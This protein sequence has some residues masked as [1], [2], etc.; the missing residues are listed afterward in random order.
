MGPS[1]DPDD[2][3]RAPESSGECVADVP[4]S[5]RLDDF[6]DT[7]RPAVVADVLRGMRLRLP[8]GLGQD[9]RVP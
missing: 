6:R 7:R 1:I 9:R 8:L 4:L 2:P 3:I 5:D